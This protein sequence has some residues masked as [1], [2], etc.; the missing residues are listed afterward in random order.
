MGQ[1]QK[2]KSYSD[3][4]DY[5]NEEKDEEKD[6]DNFDDIKI[7]KYTENNSSSCLKIKTDLNQMNLSIDEVKE[8]FDF[9]K[10]NYDKLLKINKIITNIKSANLYDSSPQNILFKI[11]PLSE[12]K[13]DNPDYGPLEKKTKELLG[14]PTVLP[15]Y[16][17][18]STWE[19]LFK[20]QSSEIAINKLYIQSKI[21][22]IIKDYAEMK[23][24]SIETLKTKINKNNYETYEEELKEQFDNKIRLII[25]KVKNLNIYNYSPFDVIRKNYPEYPKYSDYPKKWENLFKLEGENDKIDYLIE[26]ID[27]VDRNKE[28]LERE[29]QER[30]VREMQ[31]RMEEKEEEEKRIKQE[32]EERIQ[33]EKDIIKK[34]KKLK[35]LSIGVDKI[36]KNYQYYID[37]YETFKVINEIL[38]LVKK[39]EI[40]ETPRKIFSM[41]YGYNGCDLDKWKDLI[42]LDY[43]KDVIDKLLKSV[44]LRIAIKDIKISL[45][46]LN[47]Y[48]KCLRKEDKEDYKIEK[49]KYEEFINLK[50]DQE[51]NLEKIEKYAKNLKRLAHNSKV[52]HTQSIIDLDEEIR[53]KREEKGLDPD[54][55][56]LV[57]THFSL[58]NDCKDSCMGCGRS[59]AFGN[60]VTKS[61]GVHI[62][63]KKNY[64]GSCYIC[65][66]S[67]PPGYM[68]SDNYL[69]KKCG[70]SNQFSDVRCLICGEKFMY[71]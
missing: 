54:F 4:E 15:E 41:A 68:R 29:R 39:E 71:C 23:G 6:E 14:E 59:A 37:N 3:E 45:F 12:I 7:N 62:K 2:G 58:C 67:V 28:R 36:K 24:D 8:K 47:I 19:E 40:K 46:D 52:R 66:K 48:G 43:N 50:L 11:V 51:S 55:K 31:R 44:R 10:N 26:V 70:D 35:A 22:R 53:R 69:C 63:C 17:L 20:L 60:R 32:K 5:G 56:G 49:E 16:T 21:E 27:Y 38:S 9:Y 61:L 64:M 65:R 57:K 33:N 25:Q 18:P 13:T 1:D 42:K 30:L 34:M